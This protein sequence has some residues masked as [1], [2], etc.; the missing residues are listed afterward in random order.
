M[1]TFSPDAI[2][3]ESLA[4]STRES[5]N[6]VTLPP[7]CY[8]SPEFF[9]F[10]LEAVFGRSW[11]AVTHVDQI[12]NEGDYIQV[13]IGDDPLIVAR[14]GNGSV[15][16]MS[17]V[18]RHRGAVIATG[19]GNCGGQLSCPYHRWVYRLEDGS[20]AGAPHMT[21][22]PDF[23]RESY[24]LPQ[25]AV[26]EWNGFIFASFAGTPPAFT[27]DAPELT[28]FLSNY[29]I[30]DLRQAN[31]STQR[32]AWN[33]KIMLE[34]AVECYHCTTLHGEL[35]DTAPT[36]NSVPSPLNS[37]IAF[38]SR[39]RNSQ[40]DSEFTAT[41]EAMFPILSGLS[42]VE[43]THSTW[44]IVAPNLFLSL[45]HDNVHYF[46]VLPK[47]VDESSLEIG[48]LYPEATLAQPDFQQRF[49]EGMSAWLPI[50]DQDIVVNTSVQRGLTSRF[51]VRGPYS[52]LEDAL[53]RFN[54]WLVHQ[55]TTHT[56]PQSQ[57]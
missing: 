9:A 10:E 57:S 32:I 45:Q 25:L 56:I 37:D 40:Q 2:F 34:N 26:R 33:W 36:R 5:Q 3:L 15:R 20:L 50:V 43:R 19:K 54:T 38:A 6:P 22:T 13:D 39:V 14:T 55:Y 11:F 28:G 49:Q 1:N 53:V 29:N 46:L 44:L 42:Q 47:R 18:C 52:W 51:A 30:G 16:V 17:A 23:H 48:Y 21:K 7:A 35:H 41:G 31:P 27:P 12:P 24:S 4:D 8:A